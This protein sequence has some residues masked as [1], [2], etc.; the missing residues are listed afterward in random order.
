MPVI[1]GDME[2][3]I[4]PTRTTP[5]ARH[6]MLRYASCCFPYASPVLE[7]GAGKQELASEGHFKHLISLSKSGAGEGIRTLDPN[8]GK[9]ELD[10]F[11][12]RQW[13]Q[14]SPADSRDCY[15]IAGVIAGMF[16]DDLSY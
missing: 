16:W 4:M 7:L 3:R 15:M 11:P 5:N 14:S 12:S 6:S 8:L 9:V 1:P 10:S 13:A 2:I